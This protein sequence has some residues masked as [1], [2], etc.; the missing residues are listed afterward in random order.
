MRFEVSCQDMTV[1]FCAPLWY[2]LVRITKALHHPASSDS[3]SQRDV[4]RNC[5]ID[6][7][8]VGDW[9]RVFSRPAGSS[10]GN[11]LLCHPAV[12]QEK[13]FGFTCQQL[14]VRLWNINDQLGGRSVNIYI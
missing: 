8:D 3:I 13:H 4:A 5:G 12:L 7:K 1:L 9:R 10:P 14:E 6:Q 11:W 2:I